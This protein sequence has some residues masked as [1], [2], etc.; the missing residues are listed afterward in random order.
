MIQLTITDRQGWT[1]DYNID[2]H[3]AH[4]G[5]D[6]HNDIVLDGNRGSGV[7]TRHVQV[8]VPPDPAGAAAKLV[9]LSDMD[10][11]LGD[12]GLDVL[13]PRCIKPLTPGLT[14][15][16]GEFTLQVRQMDGDVDAAAVAQ[17]RVQPAML[18][19]S[20]P[21]T[22]QNGHQNGHT[23]GHTNGQTNGHKNGKA[24]LGVG[25]LPSSRIGV[26]LALL[27]SDLGVDRCIEGTLLLRNN[28]D[29]AG[30]QFK[31]DIQG[32][33]RG[34]YELEPAPVLFPG[35][36]KELAL[37]IFHPRTAALGAGNHMLTVRAT[38]PEA[39]PSE[40]GSASQ[41]L[42][43]LPYYAHAVRLAL[44]GADGEGNP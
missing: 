21:M 32:L 33:P 43:V 1:R 38:A 30:V 10:V 27:S 29:R 44:P 18:M 13:A 2:K 40:M 42:R 6:A 12:S 7:A 35:A 15:R 5:S 31:V 34:C 14:F 25:G 11:P 4:I 17:T 23:N 16:L 36:G 24:K 9:N 39:Y 22:A 26:Q 28:G 20:V 41:V 8:L 37:R 3:I 19:V